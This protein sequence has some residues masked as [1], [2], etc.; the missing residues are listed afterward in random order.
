MNSAFWKGKN[1]FITGGEGFIGSWIAKTLVEAG[2]NVTCLIRDKTAESRL[3]L[4]SIR[5]RIN[6]VNG[7]VEDYRLVE[8]SLADYDVEY[9]LHLAAQSI[10]G[11][12]NKSPVPTLQVNIQGTWNVLEAARLLG[13]KVVVASSDKA[14]GTHEK[15]PYTEEMCLIGRAPYEVSK[16]C[17]DLLAQSYWHTYGLKVA[18]TRCG[19]VYGGGD[20]NW[21]RIV[22]G[23]IRSL[24]M[25]ED[26]IIR[27]DGKF[28]RDYI[29][30]K[31]AVNAYLTLAE[32][33]EKKGVTGQAFNF[34]TETPI[35]VVELVN[36]MVAISGKKVQPKILNEAKNEILRQ[37]LSSEKAR[38]VLEWQPQV[39]LDQG[40]KEA[41]RW[42][43]E[44]FKKQG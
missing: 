20:F 24:I 34:G 6:I 22:P 3:E 12:A 15:L 28:E 2:S 40:L 43:E 5:N 25:G 44:Y 17:A 7:T 4:H 23:T 8:R 39:Q 30:V 41:Y 26:I 29:Y 33:I 42:Y 19:N 14:Y 38:K 35:S 10:V 1:V 18:V 11:I 31:D 16:S 21:N 13:V 32:N 27:S 37:Y 36:K 9:C